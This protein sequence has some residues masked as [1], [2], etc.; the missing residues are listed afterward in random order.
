MGSCSFDTESG[1]DRARVG[2]L[3][4][5]EKLR[6]ALYPIATTTAILIVWHLSVV[7]FSV[8]EFIL[9]GPLAVIESFR[10]HLGLI[11]PNFLVTT[12][13]SVLGLFIAIVFSV[14]VSVAVVWSRPME[15]TLMPLLVFFQTT[16][17]LAVAPLFIVWLGFGY[18]P[19]VIISFW[20]AYFPIVIA[21]ITGLKDVQPEMIDLTRAM[22]AST[23]QTFI[24]VRIPNALPHFFAGLKL[25]G[26]VSVLG[27]LVGEFV[28]AH[29]GLGYL[30]TMAQHNSDV[31]L[32]FSVVTTLVILGRSIYAVTSWTERHA[33]SWHV[34]M[35]TKEMK[36]FTA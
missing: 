34:T 4:W 28:G 14:V 11:W 36:F 26:V 10:G 2:K 16:P 8:P 35:R 17:K 15:K 13:E 33:I 6:N 25:G 18:T 21:T 9:P 29:E 22:S 27:A 5:E 31:K 7:L 3:K 24:K 23:L 30:I 32:L 19:K 1:R 12:F 20:L